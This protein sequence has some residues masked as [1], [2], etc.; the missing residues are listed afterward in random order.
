MCD[1][2][3]WIEKN[4]KNWFVTDADLEAF[5]ESHPGNEI[6]LYDS[7]GHSAVEKIWNVSG[8]HMQFP[9]N[10]NCTMMPDD[11]FEAFHGGKMKRFKELYPD[12][13]ITKRKGYQEIVAGGKL[14]RSVNL[15]FFKGKE[16]ILSGATWSGCGHEDVRGTKVT[17]VK[18]MVDGS[19][20]RHVLTPNLGSEWAS[21]VFFGKAG[22]NDYTATF[23]GM[24][25]DKK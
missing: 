6:S 22:R 24:G 10:K 23:V 12:L 19:R 18:S 9:M 16:V 13:K 4:G 15:D 2:V 8:D 3:S 17:I 25:K 21:E 14:Y 11:V 7:V 5:N 1:M 20:I